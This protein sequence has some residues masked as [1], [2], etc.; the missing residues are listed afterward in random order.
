MT[1][2]LPS[3]SSDGI[4]MKFHSRT[5]ILFRHLFLGYKP[6]PSSPCIY[7]CPVHPTIFPHMVR[8]EVHHPPS[9]SA[10]LISTDDGPTLVHW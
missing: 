9:C 5:S 1:D 3:A 6:T 4:A 10:H 7:L 2:A 8:R